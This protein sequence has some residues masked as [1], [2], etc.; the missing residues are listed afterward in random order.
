MHSP[1]MALVGPLE[2]EASDLALEIKRLEGAA[3]AVQ[4]RSA[5]LFSPKAPPERRDDYMTTAK[6]V[7]LCA[8]SPS[9]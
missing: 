9:G 6:D 3:A 4:S 1:L 2:S 7:A 8:R 5:L